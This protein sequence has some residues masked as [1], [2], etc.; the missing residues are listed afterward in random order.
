MIAAGLYC[1]EDDVE[2]VVRIILKQAYLEVRRLI[3]IVEVHRSP[4]N[5]E[6]AIGR[7][8]RY[9]CK[10]TA[11]SGKVRTTFPYNAQVEVAPWAKY[12]V[13]K[14]TDVCRSRQAR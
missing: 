7:A 8:S 2:A 5:V 6:D 4:F 1:P 12:R 11:S 3:V 10:H 13:I 9:R 14:G